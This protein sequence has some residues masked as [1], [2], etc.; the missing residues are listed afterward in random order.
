MPNALEDPVRRPCVS[1]SVV[2]IHDQGPGV[3]AHRIQSGVRHH[4]A[5][6]LISHV[7]LWS[8]LFL[9]RIYPDLPFLNSP[10]YIRSSRA[11]CG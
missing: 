11:Y 6:R 7:V 9:V 3:C 8:C 1:S 10:L 4:L 2:R 5:C